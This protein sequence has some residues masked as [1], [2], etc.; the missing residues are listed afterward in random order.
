MV[1]TEF[2]KFTA[3]I[4]SLGCGLWMVSHAATKEQ[5]ISGVKRQTTTISLSASYGQTCLK[6]SDLIC[7]IDESD[8]GNRILKVVPEDCLEVGDRTKHITKN[9]P[10]TSEV[11]AYQMLTTAF[12]GSNISKEKKS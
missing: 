10:F 2:L 8:A 3:F 5:K 7:Y 4:R 12:S 1:K 6:M 9:I 11:E